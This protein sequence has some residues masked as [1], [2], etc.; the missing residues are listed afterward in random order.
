MHGLNGMGSF[1]M[2]QLYGKDSGKGKSKAYSKWDEQG[3][4]IF[5]ALSTANLLLQVCNADNFSWEWLKAITYVNVQFWGILGIEFKLGE[6]KK[7]YER[8]EGV[9]IPRE[10]EEFAWMD[11]QM[12]PR[13]KK[14]GQAKGQTIT[15]TASLFH[16]ILR[17]PSIFLFLQIEG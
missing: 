9:P 12:V 15:A 5:Y 11:K 7:M 10:E 4:I 13:G 16:R 6:R 1:F 8:G 14:D 17:P 3:S 2:Q